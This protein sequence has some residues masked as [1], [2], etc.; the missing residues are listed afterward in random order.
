MQR[1]QIILTVIIIITG[2]FYYHL[3]V[4]KSK[5]TQTVLVTK[6]T[7]GDTFHIQNSLK[8]RLKG[9]NTPEKSMKGFQEAKDY[10]KNYE[11]KTLEI[12]SHGTDKYSRVL[13]HV[14][15][16]RTHINREILKQGLGTLYYYEKDSHY[17]ALKKAEQEARENELGIWKKSSNSHC[18]ELIKL[19]Y[20][21]PNERCTD[22]E[23]LK[24]KNNCN[25]DIE[26]T[27]KDDATHIY[28]ETLQQNS[29]FQKIFSCIWN[30][31][32]DSLYVW[33][34]EGLLIFYRY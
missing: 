18:I 9:I 34:K 31:A 3:T 6:I 23:I 32:G 4:D 25:K 14:F 2:I 30:D 22:G 5:E 11:N 15:H 20:K 1:K 33:D 24:L 7:D 29:E 16:Q 12:E 26:I 28:K 27:F 10:L 21:E 19:Q 13:A 8:V 17:N